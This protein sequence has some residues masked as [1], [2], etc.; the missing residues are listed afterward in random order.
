M[1]EHV[2]VFGSNLAGRH[3]RGA[4]LHAKMNYGAEYGVGIGRTGN[5]YAIPTKDERLRVLPL[6]EIKPHVEEFLR[7]VALHPDT[8]FLLSAVGTGLAGYKLS[9]IQPLFFPP[10][11]FVPFNVF[12]SSEWVNPILS[13]QWDS[14][15]N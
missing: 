5:A 15:R 9:E 1:I 6:S 11:K 14:G 3:G 10:G 12:L 13:S 7:Y 2:F 4:A 8:I